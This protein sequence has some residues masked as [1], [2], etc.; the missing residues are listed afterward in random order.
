M[1]HPG[2]SWAHRRVKNDERDAADLVDLLRLG[3]LGRLAEADIAP[4]GLRKLRELVR[5]RAL[6][7]DPHKARYAEDRI[8]P[9]MVSPAWRAVLESPVV[10]A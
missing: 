10:S 8:M 4:P 1:A 9:R 2:N 6:C 7:R 3:R 5:H